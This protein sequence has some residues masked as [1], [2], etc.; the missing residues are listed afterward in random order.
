M[1]YFIGILVIVYSNPR[2][3][4][5]V[6]QKKLEKELGVKSQFPEYP[7]LLKKPKRVN[8][9][10]WSAGVLFPVIESHEN[11]YQRVNC[12]NAL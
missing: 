11:R 12:Y 8:T 3:A 1:I 6:I 4:V 9:T 2:S 10:M 5:D 7:S